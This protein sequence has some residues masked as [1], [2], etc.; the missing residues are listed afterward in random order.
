MSTELKSKQQN[1]S[2]LSGGKAGRHSRPNKGRKGG[3]SNSARQFLPDKG[4]KGGYI[5]YNKTLTA[6]ARKN[7]KNPTPAEQKLWH[8]VL[9]SKRLDNLKFTRQ[10]PLD[11]YIVD[12]YCAELMLAIEI[13]GD[14]HAGQKQHD[15]D[16]TKNLNKFGVE[17]IRYTNAEVLNNLEGVYQDL[18]KRISAR[19]LSKSCLEET[20]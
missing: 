17:V 18:H 4:G 7:R 12:F 13:D 10:K 19:K 1:I 11:E 6:K 16:R 15:K 9:Q 14:T 5:P 3:Y 2:P 8:E 20:P